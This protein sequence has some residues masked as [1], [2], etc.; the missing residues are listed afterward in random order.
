MN[1]RIWLFR[2]SIFLFC[3]SPA[4]AQIDSTLL[5]PA[6]SSALPHELNMDA[7]LQRPGVAAGNLSLS[8]GGYLEANWQHLGTDGVSDGHQFQFRRITLFF[9]SL[10]ARRIRFMSEIEFEEG[11]RE[12]AIESA[13]LD[14]EFFPALNLR[15]G[16]ILNPI[17][18][19]NQNHDGPKW[20]FIDRPIS[21]TRLLPGTWSNPGF[22]LFGK[23]RFGDLTAGYEVYLSGGFDNSIIAN[24]ENRTFLPAAKENPDRFEESAS[25]EPL[26]TAKAALR[27]G[28]L[29]EI[30]LSF[31]GG[32]YNRHQADGFT[33]DR[34]R[35]CD[36]VA[37][38]AAFVVPGTGSRLRGEW[39]WIA[40]DV[41]PTYSQQFGS[42]QMGGHLDIVHPLWSGDLLGWSSAEVNL[43][44]RLES[45][46]WNRESF[47]E[48]G[49]PI[50][51]ELWSIVAAL[52]FRPAAGT[53]LRLNFRHQEE[54][55]LFG[56]PPSATGGFSL[57]FSTYF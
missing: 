44:V 54:T 24:G 33:L 19:F 46:D 22:G 4:P 37:I 48:T 32:V 45:V 38:D 10:I 28:G 7:A 35:R 27:S 18:A 14:I 43:G 17:G 51:D 34:R 57:G 5:K 49:E 41:P 23:A 15:G 1:D 3:T 2:I 47:R 20:E 31:M 6:P 40:V 25:G 42:R 26:L 39:T 50:G 11:A 8:V 21:A 13:T 16:M 12:I 52:S 56:N 9:S 36:V 30:G 29:G 55:D 53:V